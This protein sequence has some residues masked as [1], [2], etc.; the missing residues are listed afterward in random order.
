MILVD[1]SKI[2]EL[3]KLTHEKLKKKYFLFKLVR[4]QIGLGSGESQGN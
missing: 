2:L 4:I 1:K 3:Y